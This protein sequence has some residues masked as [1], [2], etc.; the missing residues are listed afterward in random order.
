MPSIAREMNELLNEIVYISTNEQTD[1]HRTKIQFLWAII[2]KLILSLVR[3]GSTCFLSVTLLFQNGASDK[4]LCAWVQR[5]TYGIL[6]FSFDVRNGN[7]NNARTI[8]LQL[9]TNMG[10]A[11]RVVYLELSSM[12]KIKLFEQFYQRLN[13]INCQILKS[14]GTYLIKPIP[15]LH[16]H[17]PHLFENDLAFSD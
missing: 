12:I 9:L 11:L 8:T 15:K 5:L 1:G 4:K 3:V 14:P 7:F 17:H 2:C 13:L 16:P 6:V 10:C